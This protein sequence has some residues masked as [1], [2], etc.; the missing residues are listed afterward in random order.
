VRQTLVISHPTKYSPKWEVEA[1]FF[2]R[3]FLDT[4]GRSQDTQ[5][6]PKDSPKGHPKL[7]PA[8]GAGA[9]G[10]LFAS[11]FGD[12]ATKKCSLE[13]EVGAAFVAGRFFV[14]LTQ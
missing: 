11:D 2:A 10:G 8:G 12:F 14:D 7:G 6:T 3:R 9:A 1:V 13:W 4:S 5:R